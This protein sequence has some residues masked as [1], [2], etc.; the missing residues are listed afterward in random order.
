MIPL[1][2]LKRDVQFNAE[3]TQV[4]EVMKGIA[5]SR[6]FILEKQLS[7]YRAFS[8]ACQ[9]FL[10]G[11][12]LERLKH[13]FVRP[14]SQRALVLLV[15]SDAGF[16]GGLNARVV[17][18]GLETAGRDGVLAVIGER[19][20]GLLRELGR[21]FTPFPGIQ[22]AGRQALA[23]AVR[24]HLVRRFFLD[25]CGRMAVVYP[26]PVSFAVQQVTAEPLLPVT[27][28]EGKSG[29]RFASAQVIW[30][31][32]PEEV[33]EYAAIQQIGHR[34]ATLFGLSRLAELAARAVHLEWSSQELQRLGKQLRHLYFRSRHEG[35][36]RSMREIFA[37][38]LLVRSRLESGGE[39]D[40]P[41]GEESV[42]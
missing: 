33:V 36:D 26:R 11:V 31:S 22:D 10:S 32:R 37:T 30:E 15:T 7:R 2:R 19:G 4:V 29:S 21:P 8:E 5:A 3:L 25:S 34:L 42:A 17:N 20:A 40:E 18:E 28:W 13:P 6:Y 9:E 16:L 24:D 39:E 23:G 35:I 38:Q 14:V 41:A 12:D 27:E 1:V